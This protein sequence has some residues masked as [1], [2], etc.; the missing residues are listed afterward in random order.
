M[1]SIATEDSNSRPLAP[2]AISK[3]PT[4]SVLSSAKTIPERQNAWYLEIAYNLLPLIA[5]DSEHY[6]APYF[7]YESLDLHA[8]VPDGFAASSSLEREIYAFGVSYKPVPN[9]V[10]KADYRNF[11]SEAAVD[12]ADELAL[13][14]GVAF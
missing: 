11:T 10:I 6:L 1:R 5:P 14:V 9:V 2:G 13:G 7:R 4:C 8:E 12:P 3:M